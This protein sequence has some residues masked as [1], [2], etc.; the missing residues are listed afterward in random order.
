MSKDEI[1]RRELLKILAAGAAT[2]GVMSGCTH[3]KESQVNKTA[4]TSQGNPILGMMPL[5]Q[6]GPWPT[7][8]PFLFCVHHNDQYPAGTEACGPQAS[9]AGRQIGQDFS[10]LN[11]W[12]MYHGSTVPGFPRHPHRGF[13]TITVVDHGIIDHSDSLGAAARYGDGDVQW[14]TAGNGINH[15]EMFPLLEQEQ[16]NPMDFFQIWLNLPAKNKRV[17]PHFSMF[18][19]NDI[20]VVRHEGANGKV[21]TVRVVAGQYESAKP[22]NPPPNSWAATDESHVAL[23]TIELD[24]EAT[25]TLPAAPAQANRNLYLIGSQPISIAQQSFSDRIRLSLHP[26]ASVQIENGPQKSRLL[27]LQGKPIGEPVVQHGPFVMNTREEIVEAIHDYQRDQF[28]GW[29]WPNSDP[30]HGRSQGRF[31][32]HADQKTE[33]PG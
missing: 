31:A 20:P 29:P 12:S 17:A 11:G 32:R 3:P 8:D 18:W 10:A 14:L 30:I 19:D 6:T 22:L 28:G 21:T 1:S 4:S 7:Q 9:L 16:P 5:P 26:E 2:A 33:K 15:A 23:W 13:E 24:P 25:W 27:L